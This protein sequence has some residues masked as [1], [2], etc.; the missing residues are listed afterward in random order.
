MLTFEQ[1]CQELETEIIKSYES[2]VSLEEAEK[3]AGKFLHGQ[4]K[5][6]NELKARDLDARMRKSGLKAVRA[7]V[8]TDICAKADKKPTE[9]QLDHMLN[10]HDLVSS[11]Q[12]A[13]DTAEVD[14]DALERYYNIFANAH[15][16]LR[17][18]AKGSFGG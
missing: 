12:D 11:E 4:I 2:G 10:M 17:G 14:R 1:F 8:Y 9:G 6:S 16:F 18:V 15:I 5:V 7:A 3:L 13:L